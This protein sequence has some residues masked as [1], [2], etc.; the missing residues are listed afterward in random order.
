[1]VYQRD[2]LGSHW[3]THITSFLTRW[4]LY[5]RLSRYITIGRFFLRHPEFPHNMSSLS[6]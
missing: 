2:A 3:Y 4:F 6:C 5:Y 1:M